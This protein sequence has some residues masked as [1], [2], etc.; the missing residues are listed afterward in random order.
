MYTLFGGIGLFLL[1]MTLLTDGLKAF[2]A[3]H[4]R[5]VLLRFTGKPAKAFLTGALATALVQSSSATTV[6]MIGFV[7]AGLLGFPQAI[8]VLLGA[9]LGTTSTGW[10]VSVL[11][12][13][14]SIGYYALP[15]V[16]AGAFL[17]L[18]GRGRWKSLGLALA[19]FGLIFVG[20]ETLQQAMSGLAGGALGL[21]KVPA[22]GALG[23][24][25]VVAAGVVMTVLLQSSSAAVATTLTALHT[26]SVNFE[27][28]ALLVVGASIGTTATGAL[29]SMGANVPAKRTALALILLNSGTG[30]ISVLLLPLFLAGIRWAQQ[31]AGLEAGA[32]SLAAFH[33]SF[34]AFGVILF[35]PNAGRFAR[36]VERLIPDRAPSLTAFLDRSLLNVPTVALEATR[37]SLRETAA[38]LADL[39]RDS[40]NGTGE[41]PRREERRLRIE[42]A[43]ERT[44]EFFEEIPPVTQDRGIS[45]MRVALL[46]AMDHL[47]RLQGYSHLPASVRRVLGHELLRE[48]AGQC[49]E[50]LGVAASGLRGECGEIWLENVKRAAKRM[51][52]SSHRGR[53]ELMRQTAAGAWPPQESLDTLDGLRWFSRLANHVWRASR[54]LCNSRTPAEDGEREFQQNASTLDSK[55]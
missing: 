27:Q 40:L 44:R 26:G 18:L 41:P 29:A 35:L 43:L 54:H 55:E 33:T 45:K 24:A 20:I 10:I 2:A 16:G 48:P 23:K 22:G 28:A 36:W 5:T 46:H 25:L 8:G 51:R 34:T 39:V 49:H 42:Q 7:S 31:H 50:L 3:D 1:G 13:K 38:E 53:P 21:S 6:T 47:Q 11:G 9:S 37:R 19:G 30:L 17:K 12:L 15:M 52:K 4:L 32:A 14:V